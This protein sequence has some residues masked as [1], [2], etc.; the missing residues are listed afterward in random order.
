MIWY[1]DSVWSNKIVFNIFL[2][3]SHPSSRAKLNLTPTQSKCLSVL[4][5]DSPTNPNNFPL[6][7]YLFIPTPQLYL[8]LTP[9]RVKNS[10]RHPPTDL[11]QW[12][13][14]PKDFIMIY[15]TTT[16]LKVFSIFILGINTTINSRNISVSPPQD[17]F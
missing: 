6:I 7:F 1:L 16:F 14:P 2:V 17:I 12:R 8:K 13:H 11:F 4:K 3:I 10:F 5:F 9:P 15:R